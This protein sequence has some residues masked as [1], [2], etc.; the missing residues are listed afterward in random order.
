MSTDENRLYFSEE[1]KNKRKNVD[2]NC[3][4]TLRYSELGNVN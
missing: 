2:E 1:V 4:E 3:G